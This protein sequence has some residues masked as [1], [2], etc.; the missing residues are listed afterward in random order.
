MC[1]VNECNNF[2]SNKSCFLITEINKWTIF[3]YFYFRWRDIIFIIIIF[4]LKNHKLLV[5]Y[6]PNSIKNNLYILR[7][8]TLLITIIKELF[9]LFII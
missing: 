4:I 5:N 9:H 8:K 1:G 3:D 7:I 6:I 2:F